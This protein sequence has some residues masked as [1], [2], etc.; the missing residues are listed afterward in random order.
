MKRCRLAS[1]ADNL[2]DEPTFGNARFSRNLFEKTL[3]NQAIRIAADGKTDKE[4]LQRI[5]LSDVI[6][7]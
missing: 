1:Q 7:V 3:E 6:S 2:R 5:V 4:S